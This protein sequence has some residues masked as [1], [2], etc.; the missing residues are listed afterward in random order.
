MVVWNLNLTLKSLPF[1]YLT[2][3]RCGNG[4]FGEPTDPENQSAINFSRLA[5]TPSG[6]LHRGNAANF[7][8]NA[9]LADGGRLLLRIDD[10]DRARFRHEYLEDIFT[11]I[12][13]LG[14][15][16]T[17]GPRSPADFERHWSQRHRMPL[18][19]A[20]LGKLRQHPL[21]FACPCTRKELAGGIHRHDCTTARI[22]PDAP[23]VAWRINTRGLLIRNIPD[24]VDPEGFS[25]NFHAA[26]PDFVVRTKSG[27]PSYQL[28]C[29]V[30]DEH[31]GINRV[32]R[33][34][35]LLPSTAAQSLLSELL[36]YKDLFERIEFV[37]HPLLTDGS[38]AKLSK[39]AGAQG[40]SASEA[41][42][43]ADGLQRV[44]DS[45]LGASKPK[46]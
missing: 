36:G 27:Q 40:V 8:L 7:L 9:R 6:F 43:D 1:V 37:H 19:R 42:F 22:D 45:W 31:F 25:V 35:D 41:G 2:T 46:C 44:V 28:A 30:D 11:V 26:I 5:P 3:L 38:G 24:M 15:T 34:Q 13:R 33:G 18:Y 16:V 32:G 17:D 14:I 39:S 21:V 23:G 20:A 4:P 10:L 29:T 12:G